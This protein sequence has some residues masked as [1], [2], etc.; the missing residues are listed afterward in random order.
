M[1]YKRISMIYK[2]KQIL[3]ESLGCFIYKTN[4]LKGTVDLEAAV[5]T[6][7]GLVHPPCPCLD[8]P[9]VA[10]SPFS[11]GRPASSSTAPTRC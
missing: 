6:G 4:T 7:A 2:L 10:P 9:A 11:A 5:G 3:I 8:L 1:I